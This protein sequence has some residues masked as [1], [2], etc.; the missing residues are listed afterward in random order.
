M[1]LSI[2]DEALP[3]ILL[4]RTGLQ[5]FNPKL[6]RKL[7]IPYYP[8]LCRL[9]CRFRAEAIRSD[10]QASICEDLNEILP[11]APQDVC[12]ILDIGCGI[13]GIDAALATHFSALTPRVVLLDKSAIDDRVYYDFHDRASWYNSL[14][15][16]RETLLA[17]GVNEKSLT[18]LNAE[19][20]GRIQYDGSF[21]L[22]ISLISWGFH[23]PIGVYL[24]EVKRL[25]APCGVLILDVRTSSD[26]EA[27]LRNNFSSVSRIANKGKYVR[28][29]V[30]N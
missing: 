9:E 7:R 8:R 29:K 14:E 21:D 13:A 15:A 25:L 18:L 1:S 11:H 10:Y 2:P 28:L 17:N 19:E 30:G 16:A 3:F 26:G 23:Y 20:D 5:R 24:E 22:I 4:Q 27:I 12:S 6:L